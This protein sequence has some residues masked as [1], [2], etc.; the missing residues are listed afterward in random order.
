MVSTA[1]FVG[2]YLLAGLGIVALNIVSMT[3][4]Q[5]ATPSALQARV[6]ASFLVSISGLMPVSA[7]AA[8]LL[9]DRIGLRPTLFITAAGLPVSVLWIAVSPA[10]RIKSL[11]GLAA[12]EPVA[13]RPAG[14]A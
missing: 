11:A 9:G 10:R 13:A 2:L 12:V 4:R 8:G 6:N 5:V 14:R 3:L 1:L 7:V